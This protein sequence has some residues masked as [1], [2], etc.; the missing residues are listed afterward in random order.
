[1]G[2]P[3]GQNFSCVILLNILREVHGHQI[4]YNGTISSIFYEPLKTSAADTLSMP[5]L[6]NRANGVCARF[7][8]F[9]TF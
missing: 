5:M 1:M 7:Y 8:M 3:H 6:K 2:Y 4:N 9:I